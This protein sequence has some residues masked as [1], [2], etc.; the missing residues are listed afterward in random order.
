MTNERLFREEY[1]V[2]NRWDQDSRTRANGLLASMFN[3]LF[4]IALVTLMKCL[5]L[6]KPLSIQLQKRDSDVF[7]A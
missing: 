2:W 4:I 5:S 3:F 7:K 6:D 1:G